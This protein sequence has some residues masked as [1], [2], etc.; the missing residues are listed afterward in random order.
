MACYSNTHLHSPICNGNLR[1]LKSWQVHINCINSALILYWIDHDADFVHSGPLLRLTW[2][3]TEREN[4]HYCLPCH[5]TNSSSA[6]IV[7]KNKTAIRTTATFFVL[8]TIHFEWRFFP[9]P[10]I[11]L[12]F[13]KFYVESS[14]LSVNSFFLLHWVDNWIFI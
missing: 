11:F 13:F 12:S 5:L 4:S 1:L 2:P 8:L 7:V 3:F 14:S 6:L 10:H 9:L